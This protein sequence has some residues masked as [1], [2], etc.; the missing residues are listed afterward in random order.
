MVDRYRTGGV[1]Q[2]TAVFNWTTGVMAA[3]DFSTPED[4]N[5]AAKVANVA[6]QEGYRQAQADIRRALGIESDD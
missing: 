3:R 6:Y 1:A 4:A 5:G 2:P